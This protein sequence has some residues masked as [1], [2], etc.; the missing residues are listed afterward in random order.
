MGS[1]ASKFRAAWESVWGILVL[2]RY[3]TAAPHLHQKPPASRPASA[4]RWLWRLLI[5]AGVVEEVEGP[6]GPAEG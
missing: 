3:R 5:R 6:Q 2:L 4:E 1:G